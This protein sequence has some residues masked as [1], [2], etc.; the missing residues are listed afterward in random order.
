MKLSPGQRD[1]NDRLSPSK[2]SAE[3]FLGVDTRPV[4]EIIAEDL[5][6]LDRTG[7]TRE[8]VAQRL[9]DVYQKARNMFGAEI[10]VRTRVTAVYHEAKGRIPSPFRGEGTFEKG[11]VTVTDTH[12]GESIPVTMLGIHL[13]E[14]H[15][16]FQGI[17]SPFRIDPV[18]AIRILGLSEV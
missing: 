17:G 5:R 10:T 13:I 1:L 9:R 12:S 6:T 15:G 7:V 8:T 11:Q 4:D 2:F 16:F 18:K 14:K 3:G